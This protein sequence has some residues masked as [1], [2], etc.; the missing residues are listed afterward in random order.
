MKGAV[1]F[2]VT[3]LFLAIMIYFVVVGVGNLGDT[4][5]RRACD[6]YFQFT[7][8]KIID[9]S[10]EMDDSD[11]DEK[12]TLDLKNCIKEIRFDDSENKISYKLSGADEFSDLSTDCPD[13]TPMTFDFSKEDGVLD[14][15]KKLTYDL[16]I[17]THLVFLPLC[18]GKVKICSE[19]DNVNTDPAE[20]DQCKKQQ[21]CD[22]IIVGGARGRANQCVGTAKPCYSFTT[23][24]E[25]E[26]Q[27]STDTAS[28][29]CEYG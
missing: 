25:C 24:D 8:K 27:I 28:K 11:I 13:G 15:Q 18:D 22:I 29:R 6:S 4:T 26:S 20:R 1:D 23:K 5:V 10:C 19:F 21:G 7:M 9:R 12:V 16:T 17:T 3:I 2:V 14:S